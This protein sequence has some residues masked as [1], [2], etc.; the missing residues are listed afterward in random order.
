VATPDEV[1]RLYR[2][3]VAAIRAGDKITGKEK[4]MKVVEAEQVHEQAWLWLSACVDAREEQIVCLQN[5]LVVNPQNE[6]AQR[7]LENLGVVRTEDSVVSE[8]ESPLSKE[9]VQP[10]PSPASELPA[11]EQWRARFLEQSATGEGFVSDAILIP[12]RPEPPPRSLLDLFSAWA[13]ALFFRTGGQYG[14]E[15]QYGSVPHIL[16]NIIS[17]VLLQMMAA[18]VF[19]VL[20]LA[21]GRNPNSLLTPVIDSL[22]EML[23]A[24]GQ[25]DASGLI[26]P[27][28]RPAFNYLVELTGS[29]GAPIPRI[30][31]EVAASFGTIFAGYLVLTVLFTFVGQMIQ[32]IAV[33]M[34]AEWL[35]GHGG[36]VE[37][38]LALTIGLVATS[39]V[40]IPVWVIVPFSPTTF[41][42]GATI[43]GVYQ[44]LQMANAV[45][46]AHKMNI[47]ASMGVIMIAEVMMVGVS[48]GFFCLIGLIA[49]L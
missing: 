7:G 13:N 33:N 37:T 22:N 27:P 48:G 9:T 29:G 44:F 21:V 5:V 28:L 11:D 16:V 24:M 1:D 6:A 4:L 32:A 47:L 46:A 14:Q 23:T 42:L 35:G 36:I 15:V 26:Y 30:S 34:S 31:P 40:Q 2:E 25:L 49:G 18:L 17:A 39:I 43:V 45:R 3:G 10:V 41:F 19:G 38:T 8:P 12:D 20:L